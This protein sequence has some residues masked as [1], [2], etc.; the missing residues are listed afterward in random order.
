MGFLDFFR[1]SPSPRDSLLVELA[2]IAGRKES[3]IERLERHAAMCALSNVK[4][5][6]EQLA[7]K[8]AAHLKTLRSTLTDHGMW[9]RPPEPPAHDG[10]SNWGRLSGDLELASELRNLINRQSVMWEATDPAMAKRFAAMYA[11]DYD[12]TSFLRDLTLK[13]DPQAFD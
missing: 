2:D 6:L 11:E 1:E 7:A 10:S 8:E 13:C 12:N 4:A 9:P 3:L 5:G